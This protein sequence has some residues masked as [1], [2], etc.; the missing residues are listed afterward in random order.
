MARGRSSTFVSFP[1]QAIQV[2]DDAEFMAAFETACA[3]KGIRLF[4]LPP[5]S[6]ELNGAVERANGAWRHE[7]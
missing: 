3:V 1:I 6:P 2:D 7:F 5:K 4:V